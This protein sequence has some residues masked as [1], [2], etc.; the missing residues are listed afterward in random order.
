MLGYI[1]VPDKQDDM[2]SGCGQ[3]QRG[4]LELRADPETGNARMFS[5]RTLYIMIII[6]IIIIII[7]V[8]YYIPFTI[9]TMLLLYYCRLLL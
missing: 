5:K 1:Q 3:L 6:I 4:A 9:I 7:V 8:I 2:P